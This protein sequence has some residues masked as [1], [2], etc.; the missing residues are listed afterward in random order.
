MRDKEA[1]KCDTNGCGAT[2]SIQ[3]EIVRTSRIE[4]GRMKGKKRRASRT[5]N[6][7]SEEEK[8]CLH[9]MPA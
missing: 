9:A 1:M 7:R 5:G 8:V 3:S 4:R 6:G 2:F